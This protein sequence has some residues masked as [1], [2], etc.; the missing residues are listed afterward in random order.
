MRM[1]RVSEMTEER[2]RAFAVE[3]VA[4]WNSHDLDRVLAHYRDDFEFTSPFIARV[5]G[6][7]SGRLVG[8]EAVRRYWSTAL[9]TIAYVDFKLVDV[10]WGIDRLV[11]YYERFDGRRCAESFEFGDGG[12][13]IR[14]AAHYAAAV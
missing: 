1:T 8:K 10:L 2:A 5:I 12:L 3:W 4:A 11:I 14:S 13:V 9:R 6:D 7:T